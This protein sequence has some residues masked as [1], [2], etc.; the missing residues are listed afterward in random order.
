[1]SHPPLP[2]DPETARAVLRAVAGDD[3]VPPWETWSEAGVNELFCGDQDAINFMR[4]LALW[5]HLYDD[6]IDGDKPLDPA[7]VHS[8]MWKVWVSIPL[9]PF[10]RKHEMMLRPLIVTGILNWRAANEMEASGSL[11][12]LRVAHCTRYSINDVALLVMEI[13]G[14]HEHAVKHARRARLM[15]QNDT[16]AN[17]KREHWHER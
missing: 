10:Y 15:F 17:Y 4:D 5:T 16:W 7:L 9:N 13:V 6:C 2:S 3:R 11:E 14:G 12:E 8:A 1:M